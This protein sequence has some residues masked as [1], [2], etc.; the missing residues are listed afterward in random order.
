MSGRTVS[1]RWSL[2]QTTRVSGVA[3]FIF[4][5]IILSSN[6]C[7]VN[8]P[9][10]GQIAE[11]NHTSMLCNESAVRECAAKVYTYENPLPPSK[12]HI[13]AVLNRYV[14]VPSESLD[15][16]KML[17]SFLEMWEKINPFVK[18]CG[19]KGQFPKGNPPK[20]T[21][22]EEDYFVAYAMVRFFKPRRV[23]EI[24]SGY[25]TRGIW[26]ASEENKRE[27]RPCLITCF[28]TLP[29]SCYWGGRKGR[30][31]SPNPAALSPPKTL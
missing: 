18:E 25:S 1:R 26:R 7:P 30:H 5:S 28:R 13:D 15:F 14:K 11:A 10:H 3:G 29:N 31:C 12:E 2:S 24:G 21:I 8:V 20:E 9:C 19:E 4:A 27:G 6:R 23:I 16:D 17:P 22:P